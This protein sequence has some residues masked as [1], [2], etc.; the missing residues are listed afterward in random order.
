MFK[1]LSPQQIALFAGA[2]LTSI[3]ALMLLGLEQ[4]HEIEINTFLFCSEL[5][6]IFLINY[7]VIYFFI[8][9]FIFEKIEIIYKTIYRS[10]NTPTERSSKL[11]TATDV[12]TNVEQDVMQW[13]VESRLQLE[14]LEN[15]ERYRRDYV[16]NISHE[17][18]TPIFNL[19]GLLHTL[20]DGGW[21]DENIHLKYLTRAARNADRLQTLIE[22]L[23]NI[24]KLESGLITLDLQTF[25]IQDLVTEVLEEA[26]LR[27]HERN[28]TLAM[29]ETIFRRHHHVEADRELVRHILN[30]L[31][32][33]SIKYGKENGKTIV[34]FYEAG[35]K[36]LI[37]VAD[38]G[39]GISE[40]HLKHLFDRF[41]RVDKGRSRAEG[42]S[43]LG[44]AIVKHIAEAHGD[45]V[46]VRSTLGVGST[47]GFTLKLE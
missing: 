18:R 15:L 11:D 33:N 44:L 29:Q 30:N 22:D 12:F 10:K 41:Y 25:D 13:L 24:S 14:T 46:T 6:F 17:L 34:R 31:V 38:N 43:G 47:F 35:E 8:K 19:Q 20:L 45:T 23:E 37:E 2:V 4:M 32:L 26:E 40:E 16:G 39:I 3:F 9:R 42:G 1:H 5:I 28:I 36:L 27:A 7:T 21:Q